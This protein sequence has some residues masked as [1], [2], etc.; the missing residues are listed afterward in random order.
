MSDDR[1]LSSPKRTEKAL[2]GVVAAAD[3]AATTTVLLYAACP[4][5][6]MA[7]TTV[8]VTTTGTGLRIA[9]PHTREATRMAHL[10]SRTHPTRIRPTTLAVA[11]ALATERPEAGV[12]LEA[13]VATTRATR[14]EATTV[15][16][17]DTVQPTAE[18]VATEA[19]VVI[20]VTAA[21]VVV[22]AVTEEAEEGMA[23]PAAMAMEAM[24]LGVAILQTMATLLEEEAT[25]VMAV[26]PPPPV[27]VMVVMEV[28]RRMAMVRMVAAVALTTAVEVDS[29]LADEG[30]AIE[31]L[32]SVSAHVYY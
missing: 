8:D 7:V 5:A 4:M 9:G 11:P 22:A 13:V 30:E 12:D 21:V 31:L 28:P 17:E 16:V 2:S 23:G 20:E 24:A 3:E 10:I 18:A 26:A 14:M 32:I 15:M 25:V 19:E 27:V 29:T 6:P 1:D